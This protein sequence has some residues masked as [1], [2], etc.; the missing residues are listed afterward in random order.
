MGAPAVTMANGHDESFA[1][2]LRRAGRLGLRDI[3]FLSDRFLGVPLLLTDPVLLGEVRALRSGDE[4]RDLLAALDRGDHGLP[5]DAEGPRGAL[6]LLLGYEASVALDARNPRH[7]SDPSPGPDV[8]L[9]RYRSGFRLT[10]RGLAPFFE[11]QASGTPPPPA[12]AQLLADL[13][14]DD[15]E[16]VGDGRAAPAGIAQG[17][18]HDAA[19]AHQS[20]VERCLEALRDGVIY[21]ANLAH[22]IALAPRSFREGCTYFAE[23]VSQGAPP[24]AALWDDRAFGSLLSLSPE[25][26]VTVDLPARRVASFPIKGTRPRGPTPAEDEA[27]RAELLGSEKD[28]AEHAMIVDLLRNDLARVCL[29][30]SVTVSSLMEVVSVRNVHH[31]ESCIEGHLQEGVGLASVLEATAPGGSITGAPKSTALEII[32]ELEAGPRGPYT[33]TLVA[34]DGRGRGGSSILIRTWIRPDQGEGALHVG[35]GIVV[36]SDPAAEW[37]ETLHKA[38]AFL[39]SP[40]PSAP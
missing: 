35:G 27:M 38:A 6:V 25:C 16:D 29:P 21:Q 18:H 5:H 8:V 13:Y 20:R 19:A 31:L 14:R 12:L 2:L 32:H 10:A 7:Q 23:R 22:R 17:V 26:F 39:T 33:G 37:A 24:F 28:A 15:P 9:R 36:D 40:G 1:S 11:G 3:C 4:V 34:L 30:G